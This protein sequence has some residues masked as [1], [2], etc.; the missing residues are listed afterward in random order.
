MNIIEA[1]SSGED[2]YIEGGPHIHRLKEGYEILNIPFEFVVRDDWK[3]EEK[4]IEVTRKQIENALAYAD[5]QISN[6]KE[7]YLD[8]VCKELGL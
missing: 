5:G 4:K 2:F 1:V 7:S 8:I 3:I 6:L